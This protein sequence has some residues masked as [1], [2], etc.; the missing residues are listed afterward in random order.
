MSDGRPHRF[1]FRRR[2]P[3]P[4]SV[5]Q[6]LLGR[7]PPVNA[8]IDLV[9]TLVDRPLHELQGTELV[10]EIEARH[11]VDLYGRFRGEM[12]GLYRDFLLHCLEDRL[13]SEVEREAAGRLARLLRLPADRCAVI[14]RQVARR[15]YLRSVED[16]LADGTVDPG[17]RAFLRWLQSRLEI[18]SDIA[19]NVL[20]LRRRQQGAQSEGEA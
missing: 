15:L 6:R 8:F 3:V 17:E 7:A 16:V 19:E 5:L 2:E 18:P 9:N 14:H 13:L 4:P 20:E 10:E 1:P 11:G 12:E